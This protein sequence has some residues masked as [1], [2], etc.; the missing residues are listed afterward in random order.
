MPQRQAFIVR[1]QPDGKHVTVEDVRAARA[2]QVD[3]LAD[4][5]AQIER[6]LVLG[7]GGRPPERS[8]PGDERTS[9]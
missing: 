3:A 1:V 7:A 5:G 8:A 9:P 4:V 6:W 2:A